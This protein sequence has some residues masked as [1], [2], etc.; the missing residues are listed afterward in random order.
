M[1]ISALH[2]KAAQLERELREIR[3]RIAQA[4]HAP[5]AVADD[6]VRDRS[7][8]FSAESLPVEE[9]VEGCTDSLNLYGFCVIDNLIP[10]GEVD[11]IREEVKAAR[12]KIEQNQRALQE[13]LGEEWLKSSKVGA[14]EQALLRDAAQRIEWS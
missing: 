10:S 5:E 11:D 9:V 3:D 7:Y 2:A 1:D 12:E 14:K 8:A 13:L 4:E 6:L